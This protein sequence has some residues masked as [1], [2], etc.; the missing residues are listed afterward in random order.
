MHPWVASHWFQSTDGIVTIKQT[1][2]VVGGVTAQP[3]EYPD[4]YAL[5]FYSNLAVAPAPC[6][7][8]DLVVVYGVLF[9]PT[10][11]TLRPILSLL[12][13]STIVTHQCLSPLHGCVSGH[14]GLSWTWYARDLVSSDFLRSPARTVV[15]PWCEFR[16]SHHCVFR[17]DGFIGVWVNPRSADGWVPF[18]WQFKKMAPSSRGEIQK[19]LL[20][21]RFSPLKAVQKSRLR[22]HVPKMLT[23]SLLCAVSSWFGVCSD[24][25]VSGSDS[26]WKVVLF[27]RWFG[28]RHRRPAA[29]LLNLLC[30][31]TTRDLLP[32]SEILNMPGDAELPVAVPNG[33][34]GSVTNKLTYAVP[35]P[36][37]YPD[38]YA[39]IFFSYLAVAPAPCCVRDLVVVYGVLFS[40]TLATLWSI[41]SLLKWSTIVTNQCLSPVHG[42]VVVVSF[43]CCC[44]QL[45]PGREL[46][47]LVISPGPLCYSAGT[48]SV[49]SLWFWA[50]GFTSRCSSRKLVPLTAVQGRWLRRHV[51]RS[52]RGWWVHVVTW[53]N[54]HV[55]SDGLPFCGG[56]SLEVYWRPLHLW[57]VNLCC[58]G[59]CDVFLVVVSFQ[60]WGGFKHREQGGL[61]TARLSHNPRPFLFQ[62]WYRDNMIPLASFG[63]V[64]HEEMVKCPHVSLESASF[65]CRHLE[66]LPVFGSVS[67]VCPS[68]SGVGLRW[69]RLMNLSVR[70]I[71]VLN[72]QPLQD[73]HTACIPGSPLAFDSDGR[74]GV[75]QVFPCR[76]Q[77]CQFLM[78]VWLRRD[79]RPSRPAVS[80]SDSS[81]VARVADWRLTPR[82]TS[83]SGPLACGCD[84]GFSVGVVCWL[85]ADLE[86]WSGKLAREW[87]R[88]SGVGVETVSWQLQQGKFVSRSGSDWNTHWRVTL[89]EYGDGEGHKREAWVREQFRFFDLQHWCWLQC[90]MVLLF[91]KELGASWYRCWPFATLRICPLLSFLFVSPVSVFR[92]R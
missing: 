51:G 44:W 79:F 45:N 62:R 50:D 77:V 78:A 18:S 11:A 71:K 4:H 86:G 29:F 54:D 39:V 1:Y 24:C 69:E 9:S 91:V 74:L 23:G 12:K 10:L 56:R 59:R 17:E 82:V 5:I 35:Y 87:F 25:L 13:W 7:V 2:A 88:G 73:C 64:A 53:C 48:S 47:F 37:K 30:Y 58:R 6:C 60:C 32:I 92:H 65:G 46:A 76:S 68:S 42:C 61:S 26:F 16:L 27:Q 67:P 80:K 21:S 55:D 15:L 43:S 20:S 81:M 49:P 72:F 22:R 41:L 66:W 19:L 52:R 83:R 36:M 38:Y 40:P 85:E 28:F 90:R 63:K 57:V 34:D 84:Q 3:V 31:F 14:P 89:A 8:R 70:G 33:I 75:W